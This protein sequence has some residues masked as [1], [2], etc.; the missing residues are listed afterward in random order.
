LTTSCVQ[1]GASIRIGSEPQRQP[2]CGYSLSDVTQKCDLI[3]LESPL[4]SGPR[5]RDL[6][7]ATPGIDG[8]FRNAKHRRGLG[9]GQ[10]IRIR[11]CFDPRKW[12]MDWSSR[13]PARFGEALDLGLDA[14]TWLRNGATCI[15]NG[16]RVNLH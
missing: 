13:A 8:L 14:Y 4:T 11:Q 15:V 6:E 10:T 16:L 1:I 9:D 2:A 12:L 3:R 5:S 7:L